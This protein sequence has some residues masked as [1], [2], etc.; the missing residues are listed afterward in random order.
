MRLTD[1]LLGM[2][3]FLAVAEAGSFVAAASQL[4]LTP[5]G[6]GKAVSRLEARLGV[7]LFTRTTRRVALTE[8]GAVLRERCLRLLADLD[9]AE[10]EVDA[11]RSE[12]SGPVRVGT[13]VAY[14]RIRV[15]PA[16]AA[17]AAAHPGIRLD[18]R[19]SDRLSDPVE[20][21]LDLVVRIGELP[22]SSMRAVQV[23]RIRFGVF[24]APDYLRA[25]G[26][27]GSP[28]ELAGHA[29]LGFTLTSGRPLDFTL[30]AGEECVSLSPS[31]R[32]VG[33]DIEGVLE[34]AIAGLGL[35]Y[36]PTFIAAGAVRSG[37]LRRVLEASWIDGAPVHLLLPQPR[38]VPRRV[39]AL[40][41]HLV[42]VMRG[43]TAGT[44]AGRG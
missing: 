33:D 34:A 37:A 20:E 7:R 28:A 24:A 19:M 26:E 29:R 30:G 3:E 41:D 38:Q 18:L 31:G 16:L 43:A 14:G 23:D 2:E 9:A 42:A 40:A 12:I 4:G 39:R 8:D 32:F 11:R 25:R 6:V 17:F 35:A 1:R 21:R 10:A 15:V 36:L 13:P 22:D 5:S 27:P 44:L